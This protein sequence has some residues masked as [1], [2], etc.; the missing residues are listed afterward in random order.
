MAIKTQNTKRAVSKTPT[1]T[2]IE[3][4]SQT[5]LNNYLNKS[6]LLK[7]KKLSLG[8]GAIV[9]IIIVL[10]IVFKSVFIAAIVNGEPITRLSVIKTLEKQNGKTVL[11]NLINKSLVI[12]EMKKRNIT[13]SQSDLDAE[14]KKISANIQAQGST[15]DQALA[16]QGMKM[17]D[18]ND[19]IRIQL[20]LTKMVAS[21][22]TV[23]EQEVNDFVTKNKSV[24]PQGETEL[25]FKQQA[26][27]QLRQQKL[28]VGIQ[29]FLKTLQDKAK[30]I[31]F[32]SY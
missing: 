29:Q 13:I 8:I 5:T 7:N 20:A 14:I 18:L 26:A 28:Q 17:S 21:N 15:L 23:T 19:E 12:Q 6:I 22:I 24:M 11:N 1:V 25:Q 10:I 9:L 3:T 31:N 16:A 4:K 27:Q 2:V 32:V 30:I